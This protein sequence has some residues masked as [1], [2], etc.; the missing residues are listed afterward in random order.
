MD[1]DMIPMNSDDVL[2]DLILICASELN[3]VLKIDSDMVLHVG[4]HVSTKVVINMTTSAGLN[5]SPH[6]SAE[7]PKTDDS[8]NY[9]QG[10]LE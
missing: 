7:D 1:L 2:N 3:M 9:L 8:Q 10:T 4:V 5:V 6:E